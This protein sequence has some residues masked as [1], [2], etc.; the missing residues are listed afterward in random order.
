MKECIYMSSLNYITEMLELKDNN[1]KFYENCYY[2]KK[3]KGVYHKIFEGVLTYQPTCCAKCGAIFDN[4]FEKYGF[5]TSNIK[6]P[7]VSG[8]KAILRLKKQRYLYKHY[9][10]AFI[11]GDNVTEYG[12]CI[13]KNTK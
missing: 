7:D 8:F 13:S 1:I 11:L 12:C 2:K 6:I 3:I 4:K 5:I 9:G 10:K